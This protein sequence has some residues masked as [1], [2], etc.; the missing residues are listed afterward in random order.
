MGY[1]QLAVAL[2]PELAARVSLAA[3]RQGGLGR[4]AIRRTL[5]EGAA[6]IDPWLYSETAIV[7]TAAALSSV[8]AALASGT[9][10]NV[11]PSPKAQ[12]MRLGTEDQRKNAAIL[13][14]LERLPA[15]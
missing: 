7:T 13:F 3:E 8:I 15:P 11:M 14:G 12:D 6:L 9:F 1:S 2:E 4:W 5:P 10:A